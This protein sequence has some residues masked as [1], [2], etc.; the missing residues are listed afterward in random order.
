MSDKKVLW[1]VFDHARGKSFIHWGYG[2]V[3][4]ENGVRSYV[5][6]YGELDKAQH[7][8][9]SFW[10]FHEYWTAKHD[11]KKGVG[12][13]GMDREDVENHK[14]NIC[15]FFEHRGYD[16][17][18]TKARFTFWM[19]IDPWAMKFLDEEGGEIVGDSTRY[20][21]G[22]ADFVPHGS[23][24]LKD[25][26]FTPLPDMPF[27]IKLWN[28]SGYSRMRDLLRCDAGSSADAEMERLR[29]ARYEV[30]GM[31]G[32]WGMLNHATSVWN[33]RESTNRTNRYLIEDKSITKMMALISASGYKP[34]EMSVKAV[35]KSLERRI[36]RAGESKAVRRFLQLLAAGAAIAKNTT[37][38]ETT[39]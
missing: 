3:I 6:M 12:F 15:R 20:L 1:V 34:G 21:Q 14:N 9:D 23:H 35:V 30:K 18:S 7:D 19:L 13:A 17:S 10:S 38:T 26:Y 39:P 27:K 33:K 31:R 8:P 36:R 11:N 4:E 5:K 16:T 29:I 28:G 37:R 22:D 25:E 32:I 2:V 24:D